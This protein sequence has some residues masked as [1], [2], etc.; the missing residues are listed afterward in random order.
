MSDITEPRHGRAAAEVRNQLRASLAPAEGQPLTPAVRDLLAAITEVLDVPMAAKW[1]DR[2][3]ELMLR[4]SRAACLRGY[5]GGIVRIGQVADWQAEGIR[6]FVAELPVT[7][8]PYRDKPKPL[9]T[10][11]DDAQ[12]GG[13]DRG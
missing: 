3:K 1:D 2:D 11:A 6:E 12:T 5:L 4:A 10:P 13:G 8:T 7:Y 9:A